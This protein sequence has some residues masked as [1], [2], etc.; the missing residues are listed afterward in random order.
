[1]ESSQS[2]EYSPAQR[3]PSPELDIKVEN[4][5]ELNLDEVSD[6][7]I[8][9]ISSTLGKR[10][11]EALDIDASPS[12]P[13]TPSALER[14]EIPSPPK[15]VRTVFGSAWRESLYNF[16][17]QYSQSARS[18][19]HVPVYIMKVND[20]EYS[21][22]SQRSDELT[23]C[24]LNIFYDLAL[25]A[26]IKLKPENR[27]QFRMMAREYIGNILSLSKF[28]DWMRGFS[29]R[30]KK[31]KE[32]FTFE[33]NALLH[34][35]CYAL[36]LVTADKPSWKSYLSINHSNVE[37]DIINTKGA[38]EFDEMM[39][40]MD[41]LTA[42]TKP[43]DLFNVYKEKV[44]IITEERPSDSEKADK[45]IPTGPNSWVEKRVFKKETRTILA[46][47]SCLSTAITAEEVATQ[48]W[49]QLA[50]NNSCTKVAL[51]GVVTPFPSKPLDCTDRHAH[52]FIALDKKTKMEWNTVDL[53]L[54]RG[55]SHERINL[56]F[57][58]KNM[59]HIKQM[60]FGKKYVLSKQIED[61][62]KEGGWLEKEATAAVDTYSWEPN[63]I[64][65]NKTSKMS[66][67]DLMDSTLQECIQAQCT[68]RETMEKL[69]SVSSF[70]LARSWTSVKS[71]LS[72]NGIKNKHDYNHIISRDFA[73]TDATK[74]IK[75]VLDHYF[76][77]NDDGRYC[78][79]KITT[80]KT[81]KGIQSLP[82]FLAEGRSVALWITGPSQSGKS[83][84]VRNLFDENFTI[85]LGGS[86]DVRPIG[87]NEDE[88]Y[89]FSK[90]VIIM[91]DIVPDKWFMQGMK[92]LLQAGNGGSLSQKNKE[93][94]NLKHFCPQI[95]LAN[96]SP[97]K[98]FNR[99][100]ATVED[101]NWIR[102]N[103]C[104][105]VIK[106]PLYEGGSFF[107]AKGAAN[108]SKNDATF[109]Q[110]LNDDFE[111]EDNWTFNSPTD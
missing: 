31:N 88:I 27:I 81:T 22:R 50:K 30:G 43:R 75:T 44:A 78:K 7:E 4:I 103:V 2:T 100:G 9:E 20:G 8:V 12:L 46:T 1:M 106:E 73:T 76:E 91:D 63:P 55:D 84:Y 40:T 13:A 102:H 33:N 28:E 97:R 5:E 53:C 80:A 104:Q 82:V 51:Y 99:A 64:D 32:K 110:S 11:R 49:D 47:V 15:L 17:S 14:G 19:P 107:S 90:G 10:M 21:V 94:T 34:I 60:E 6:S 74:A 3:V 70:L 68:H 41:Y 23:N 71:Y 45:W 56:T 79:Y 57:M 54:Q 105:I 66:K 65:A 98:T 108:V 69:A 89:K 18:N 67:Q 35:L 25:Q 38:S 96:E 109:W 85:T 83:S 111:Y 52:V 36:A 92:V 93:P 26:G 37:R 86:W 39:S 72:D 61:L 29:L 87:D 24:D 48:V 42:T 101:Q 59:P 16:D 95:Y 58:E 62:V 77:V